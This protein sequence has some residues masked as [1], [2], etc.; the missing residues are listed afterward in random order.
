MRK[1]KINSDVLPISQQE[2][3]EDAKAS[4]IEEIAELPPLKIQLKQ[5]HI[6]KR[7]FYSV[8]DVLELSRDEIALFNSLKIKF[9][10]IQE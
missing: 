9:D 2:A 5:A 6:H 8:G 4:L 7:V 3:V 10:Y 1:K